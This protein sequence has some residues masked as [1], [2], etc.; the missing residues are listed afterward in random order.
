MHPVGAKKMHSRRQMQVQR[1][2]REIPQLLPFLFFDVGL[3]RGY[4]YINTIKTNYDLFKAQWVY[5]GCIDAQFNHKC[6]THKEGTEEVTIGSASLG[7]GCTEGAKKMHPQAVGTKKM[8]SRGCLVRTRIFSFATPIPAVTLRVHNGKVSAIKQPTINSIS[9]SIVTT[10]SC[11]SDAPP[12]PSTSNFFSL[13]TKT[14]KIEKKR[15]QRLTQIAYYQS[16]KIVVQTLLPLHPPVA[17]I[18][19]NLSGTTTATSADTYI[20]IDD[21]SNTYWC[22]FLES[23]LIGLYGGKAS[24]LLLND[25]H[26]LSIF[27]EEPKSKDEISDALPSDRPYKDIRAPLHHYTEGVSRTVQGVNSRLSGL[28]TRFT[29]FAL[30]P[31]GS[32]KIYFTGGAK[33][34]QQRYLDSCTKGARSERNETMHRSSLDAVQSGGHLWG[35]LHFRCTGKKLQR[36]NLFQSNI[37]TEEIQTATFLAVAMVNRWALS[38]SCTSDVSLPKVDCAS[39]DCVPRGG[40]VAKVAPTNAQ[41]GSLNLPDGKNNKTGD[42]SNAPYYQLSWGSQADYLHSIS[43]DSEER[44]HSSLKNNK[45]LLFTRATYFKQKN[46]GVAG[47]KK[48]LKLQKQRR[49]FE[50]TLALQEADCNISS[51]AQCTRVADISF[52]PTVHPSSETSNTC[53]AKVPTKRRSHRTENLRFSEA[54]E[55]TKMHLETLASAPTFVLHSMRKKPIALLSPM[56]ELGCIG[57]VLDLGRKVTRMSGKSKKS[58]SSFTTSLISKADA[59][60]CTY[61]NGGNSAL[62]YSPGRLSIE[63]VAITIPLRTHVFQLVNPLQF[64]ISQRDRFYPGWFRL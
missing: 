60:N 5:K 43:N 21:E 54:S 56:R 40:K 11:I 25:Q 3:R 39:S 30:D 49:S 64:S 17:L 23:R 45:P 4:K 32:S 55:L 63:N 33:K 37:G 50:S 2:S 31:V 48:K 10:A 28:T 26:L 59:K 47:T 24:S 52:A 36:G 13:T 44:Y 61:L 14:N 62:L 20:P 18:T 58:V 27:S 22:S 6:I 7:I 8:H 42:N 46:T 53:G 34:Q 29:R 51:Y 41:S 35:T 15:L 16:G 9:R 19:L 57:G 1:K 12:S 38:Y